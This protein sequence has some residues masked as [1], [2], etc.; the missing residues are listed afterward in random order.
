VLLDLRA[1]FALKSCTRRWVRSRSAHAI[2]AYCHYT[3]PVVLCTNAMGN[4]AMFSKSRPNCVHLVIHAS[5]Y[6]VPV[7]DHGSFTGAEP[8]AAY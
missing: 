8:M 4:K 7:A 3:Q 5:Q 1:A 2:G 6:L